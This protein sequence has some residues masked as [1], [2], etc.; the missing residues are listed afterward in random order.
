MSLI[1][2][3]NIS[4]KYGKQVVLSNFNLEVEKG[5][6]IGIKGESGKGKS[7]LLNIIGLLEDCEGNIFFE[8]KCISS[9][10]TKKVQKLLRNRIGYLFQNFALIDDLSVY[11]N[12]KIVLKKSSK[13]EKMI[14]IQQALEKV[15]LKD[16]INK[17][18]YQL[19]GGEQQRVS[20]ARLI[21]QESDIIL[22]D[23][24]TGSLDRKNALI[25]IK[26]LEKFHSEG[27]TIIMVSHDENLFKNCSRI[28]NL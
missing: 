12:L 10:D 17:K 28:I 27:K 4:K 6:F 18:I 22:A 7:T 2:L 23:E 3:N 5:E 19:S 25:I 9:N 21:L 15:G 11:D 14:L 20:V 24:P 8:E 16:V 26:L 13:K 1:R